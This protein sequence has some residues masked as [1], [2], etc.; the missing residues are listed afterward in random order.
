MKIGVFC[1]N[2]VGDLVMATPALRALRLE[3]PA[4]EVVGVMRG[5]LAGLLEGTGL[6]DR[7]I[8]L[9]HGKSGGWKQTF[10]TVAELRRE[11]FDLCLLLPNSLRSAIWGYASGARERVG[12]SRN[13]RSCLLTKRIPARDRS[14][15]HPVLEEYLRLAAGIGCRELPQQT[16]LAVA[17]GELQQLDKFWGKHPGVNRDEVV[18]FNSGGAFGA[19]KHWPA[20]HF[21]ILGQRIAEEL[22]KSVLV[23]CGPAER[24]IA[25]EI[26]RG[27]SHPQVVSL[28]EE[29]LSLG[30][31]K[32]AISRASLL[33]TTDSGPRQFAPPFGVPAVV[34][35]GPTDQGWSRIAAETETP[36][37]LQVECGPCQQRSCPLGTHRCMRDLSPEQ[38]YATVVE[39][40]GKRRENR[41]AAA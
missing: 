28:A 36:L 25:R 18:C 37:Q 17:N 26:V 4:A 27:A 30:L 5:Y 41:K 7:T 9:P 20:E 38:V 6:L 23:V 22:G 35:Y 31:T 40:L 16:E 19:A 3:Y 13:G 1:P 29:E 10:R 15:P 32:A 24:D 8:V 14:A 39:V 11:K 12:F 34:L 33:V 2:W 21:A